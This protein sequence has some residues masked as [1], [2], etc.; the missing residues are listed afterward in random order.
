MIDY[1]TIL[2]V[3]YA[4]KQWSLDGDNYS[5]LT[6]LDESPKPSK[7]TLDNLWQTVL[8]EKEAER[9]AKIEGKA[10]L[11]ERLGI[12]ADEAALLLG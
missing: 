8:D 9:L 10:A 1:A 6:W 7:A 12:T 11:L 4:G 5:G 3:K 2:T